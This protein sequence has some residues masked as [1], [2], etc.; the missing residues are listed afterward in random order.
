MCVCVCL[1]R[2]LLEQLKKYL[3]ADGA[4]LPA[5][6]MDK[7]SQALAMTIKATLA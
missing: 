3:H 5:G 6:W 7:S 2:D 4:G 1:G